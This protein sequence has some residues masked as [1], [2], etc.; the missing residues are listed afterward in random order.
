MKLLNCKLLQI[1]EFHD[2]RI[3]KSYAILSHRWEEEEVTY[4]DLK[5][6][7]LGVTKAGWTKIN[8]FC[9]IALDNGY[10]WGWVDT[11]CIDKKNLTELTEA[12][13]SMFKWYANSSVCIAYLSDITPEKH[14]EDSLWFTR[15]WTL[16]E[17]IAPSR[18][19]FYN[20]NWDFM[21]TR[22]ALSDAI[23]RRSRVD[24]EI[25][26]DAGSIRNITSML[27][28]IPIARRMSWASGR[29]TT[30]EEDRAYSLLG[31]FSV[32]MPM[33]YG[34]GSRAFIRLQEEIAKENNDLSLFAWTREQGS[35]RSTG[36]TSEGTTGA[37]MPRKEVTEPSGIFA[38]S[39]DEFQSCDDLL[40]KRDIKYNPEVRRHGVTYG[41]SIPY[42]LSDSISSLRSPTRD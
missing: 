39:P 28:R 33:L 10:E 17:L 30:R 13:N 25:L 38:T 29:I 2:E 7:G 4:K 3:P 11:C 37:A 20:K 40:L 23:Q 12:I 15:G 1:E 6:P 27:S 8:D 32:N 19:M 35:C 41:L 21:G 26:D 36:N 14:I 16:Q 18:I 9:R 5:A 24:K 42:S 31:I 22:D 34:E